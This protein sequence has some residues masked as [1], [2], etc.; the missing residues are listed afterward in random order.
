MTDIP[1]YKSRKADRSQTD[2]EDTYNAHAHN[3][4]V[5]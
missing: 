1:P 4:G 2:R 3:K 5:W